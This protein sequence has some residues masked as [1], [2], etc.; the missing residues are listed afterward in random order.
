MEQR[1]VNFSRE[2]VVNFRNFI[3]KNHENTEIIVSRLLLVLGFRPNLRGVMYLR[4]VI[5]R[6]YQ[7]PV[8]AKFSFSNDIY[9]A[10][11]TLFGTSARNIE[12]DIR[13][14][15]QACYNEGGLL[16]LNRIC[17][18]EVISQHY[19]PTNSEFVMQS[20]AWLRIEL[21]AIRER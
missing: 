2:E 12:R 16:K 15:V 8:F 21:D 19:P 18:S 4:D 1:L 9:P 11:A 5:L 7:L 3:D 17:G 13:T 20:V 10:T 6:C 14:A